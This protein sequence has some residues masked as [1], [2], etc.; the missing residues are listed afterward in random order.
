MTD[1]Q[2]LDLDADGSLVMR[3]VMLRDK[4]GSDR[5]AA[6]PASRVASCRNRLPQ[7]DS[8]KGRLMEVF[9][10]NSLPAIIGQLKDLGLIGQRCIVRSKLR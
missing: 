4:P 3:I 1:R 2:T 8:L 9:A 10:D 7:A 5:Q 6:F